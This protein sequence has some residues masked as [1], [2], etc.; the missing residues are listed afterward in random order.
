MYLILMYLMLCNRFIPI[1][2][3]CFDKWNSKR[4]QILSILGLYNQ[5]IADSIIL[6]CFPENHE[7]DSY[8]SDV[9]YL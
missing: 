7:N 2:T 8:V 5:S 4:H 9:S 3:Y 6:N 1:S